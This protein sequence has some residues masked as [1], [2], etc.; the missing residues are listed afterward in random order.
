MGRSRGCLTAGV[1]KDQDDKHKSRANLPDVTLS[2]RGQAER[3]HHA[4]PFVES[5]RRGNIDLQ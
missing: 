3:T 2:L 4:L 1:I 5:S